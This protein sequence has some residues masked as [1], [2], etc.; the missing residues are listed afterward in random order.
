MAAVET[1][2]GGKDEAEPEKAGPFVLDTEVNYDDLK[3]LAALK[4]SNWRK[5]EASP[6]SLSCTA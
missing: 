2:D 5:T 6:A 3:W 4:P 1:D